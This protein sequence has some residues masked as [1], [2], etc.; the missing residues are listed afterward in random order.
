MKGCVA[1]A[2]IA[3]LALAGCGADGSSSIQEPNQD[4]NP[5]AALIGTVSMPNGQFAAANPLIRFVQDM[6]LVPR[7]F[8][9]GNVTGTGL[10]P[11]FLPVG[12]EHPV[13]LFRIFSEVDV[14]HGNTDGALL[15]GGD[16]TNAQGRYE[17]V[18]PDVREVAL[19]CRDL[20]IVGGGPDRTRS[21]VWQHTTDIDVV[22]ETVVRLVL[23]RISFA[24]LVHLCDF[25]SES[26]LSCIRSE[27][28][29][30]TPAAV[31]TTVAEYNDNAFSRAAESGCVRKAI[32]AA[33]GGE[34]QD[35]RGPIVCDRAICGG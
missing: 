26:A 28:A 27:V 21:F 9:D 32:A 31:G 5:E 35:G 24:P 19:T 7:A 8:A 29:R 4:A 30:A 23:Q 33:T 22:S 34:Y 6:Q 14:D 2:A 20:V 13:S 15:V 11:G 3:F 25:F 17:I 18:D 1:V 16:F 10:P 12:A